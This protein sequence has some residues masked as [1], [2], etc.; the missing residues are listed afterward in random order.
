MVMATVLLLLFSGTQALLPPPAA[1]AGPPAVVAMHTQDAAMRPGTLTLKP[2]TAIAGEA[3]KV[4]GSLTPRMSR[5]VVLQRRQGSKWVKVTKGKARAGSFRFNTTTRSQSTRY[6]VVAPRVRLRGRTYGTVV[7]PTKVQTTLP[8]TSDLTLPATARVGDDE[9]VAEASFTPVRDGRPVVLQVLDGSDWVTDGVDTQDGVGRAEFPIAT[10]APRTATYRV[11]AGSW[12]GARAHSST[13]RTIAIT[14]A[15]DTTAPGPVT[16]VS[17]SNPTT[18]SLT[19]SWTNPTDADLTGVMIRRAT[20]TTPP[21]TPTAGTL[22]TDKARP[23]TTHT[24]TGL[25]PGTTYAY[26]LFAHDAVPNHA[27]AATTTA[28]TTPIAT[29]SGDWLQGQHDSERSGWAPAEAVIGPRIVETGGE[30]V[31]P[32]QNPGPAQEG[33]FFL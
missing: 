5:P 28:T 4:R 21:T 31:C 3:V 32:K 20:G 12:K 23:G 27:T 14:Q 19:L 7:T 11:V 24:D 10:S 1:A 13:A 6:R 26:A 22:V 16:A 33:E 2:S 25:T 9:V 17:A 8:Q 15:P 18:T 30:G 29:T